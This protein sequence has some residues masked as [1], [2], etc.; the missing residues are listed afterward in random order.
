[1]TRRPSSR[2]RRWRGNRSDVPALA[3]TATA[4]K[5]AGSPPAADTR[6]TSKRFTVHLHTAT[7]SAEM[8]RATL[9]FRR[10]LG[11]FPRDYAL[12]SVGFR[13]TNHY[14]YRGLRQERGPAWTVAK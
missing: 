2:A 10:D 12:M 3:V 7:E 1:M 5:A 8:T 14:R 4:H 13:A 6:P 9:N 11:R